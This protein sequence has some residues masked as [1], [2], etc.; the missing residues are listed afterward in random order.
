MSNL[1]EYAKKLYHLLKMR[2]FS[3]ATFKI[4]MRVNFQQLDKNALRVKLISDFFATEL[5]PV[6]VQAPFGDSILIIAPHQDDEVIGC[7]GALLAQLDAGKKVSILFV[8]DGGNEF[9]SLGYTRR[10]D[11]VQHREAESLR[12][13]EDLGVEDITFLRLTDLENQKDNVAS[14]IALEIERRDPAHI[15]TPFFLDGHPEHQI[16]TH[17]LSMALKRVEREVFINCY[18]VWGNCIPNIILNIDQYMKKKKELISF[19][20]SQCDA[21]DYVNTTM[22]RNM[23]NARLIGKRC[24]YAE[25]YFQA[26]K[27]TFIDI[28]EIIK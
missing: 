18:E 28:A 7:G 14:L 5:E 1:R 2:L 19:Y 10:D 12:V 6:E 21:T 13:A 4:Y 23:Y 3:G 16:V 22:G 9:R 8:C 24:R 26:P 17:A 15:F 11:L 25:R 20:E 27:N